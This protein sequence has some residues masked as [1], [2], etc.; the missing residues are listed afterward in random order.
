MP[1]AVALGLAALGWIGVA[2]FDL[3]EILHLD[4][5]NPSGVTVLTYFV[6]KTLGAVAA[7]F[8]SLGGLIVGIVLLAMDRRNAPAGLAAVMGITGVGTLAYL[9][10]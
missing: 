8:G 5:K 1:A 4:P 3:P 9:L 10:A 2:I 7:G 6:S